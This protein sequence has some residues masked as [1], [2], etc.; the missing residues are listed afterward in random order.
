MTIEPFT[1]R[2]YSRRELGMRAPKRISTNFTPERG[3]CAVH[4]GG[5][6]PKTPPVTFEVAKRI[7]LQWQNWHMDG[8]G[9]N[10]I[11]YSF[12]IT[13][14]GDIFTGRGVGVR[15]GAQ[16]TNE[17]NQSYYAIV[18]IGGGGADVSEKAKYAYKW[19]IQ[20]LR[21][22]RD[23]AASGVK[24]HRY[25][26]GTTCPD[27][28]LT[29]M[30]KTLDGKAITLGVTTVPK[31][32]PPKFPLPSTHWFGVDDGTPRSHS[33]FAYR[34]HDDYWVRRIQK[35][36]GTP[37]DGKFGPKTAAAAKAWA[38]SKRLTQAQVGDPA[39]IGP[40]MW[41]RLFA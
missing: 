17:G 15:P 24:P 18:W 40:K 8:Q 41:A 14:N 11:A 9:W 7:W 28:E 33:G 12:G 2:I 38:R 32:G 13:N 3:G 25:F 30:C 1:P 16:G 31:P 23:N 20:Q 37:V 6:G 22:V 35:I 4:H 39:K 10:D 5:G 26:V 21:K 27:A 19:L 29:A 36:V 34:G